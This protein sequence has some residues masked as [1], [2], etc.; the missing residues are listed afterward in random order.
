M[1]FLDY[2]EKPTYEAA[3]ESNTLFPTFSPDG[4][5]VAYQSATT[6]RY[7]IW[8]RSAD[9]RT[10]KQ[11]S[12]GGGLEP[13]WCENGELFWRNGN[14]FL[15]STVTTQPEL[16]WDTPRVVFE[17]D[18]VDSQG[19]SYDVSPD[20]QRLLLHLF[21]GGAAIRSPTSRWTRNTHRLGRGGV[22]ALSS[23]GEV[24]L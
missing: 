17:T 15:V 8:L 5:F 6:D 20:G 7:E 1:G 10:R 13:I 22:N 21:P 24:M 12:T 23:S 18:F 16:S 14:R 2:R 3:E 4:L 11:I 19:K 9:G